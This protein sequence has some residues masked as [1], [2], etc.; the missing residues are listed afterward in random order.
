MFVEGIVEYKDCSILYMDLL[1]TN[2]VVYL[3]EIL[4]RH[5]FVIV[6]ISNGG[7][8]SVKDIEACRETNLRDLYLKYIFRIDNSVLNLF[9]SLKT[10]LVW[11]DQSFEDQEFDLFHGEE[12]KHLMSISPEDKRDYGAIYILNEEGITYSSYEIYSDNVKENPCAVISI[13]EIENKSDPVILEIPNDIIE[14]ISKDDGSRIM[15]EDVNF[16]GYKDILYLGDNNGLYLH[17]QCNGFLWN[18]ETGKYELCKSL[19]AHFGFIDSERKRLTY[20][21]HLSIDDETYYIYEY[22]DGEFQEKRLETEYKRDASNP[23]E[24]VWNYYENGELLEKLILEYSN[25]ETAYYTFYDR[26]NHIVNGEFPEEKSYS[27]LGMQYFP[28]F[29]FYFFG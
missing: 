18:E 29:D 9:D 13:R 22:D 1:G 10:V 4:P 26:D 17:H 20:Y 3:D 23:E 24:L 5:N 11:T 16:D 12:W 21:S 28:E 2:T 15:L 25:G 19:P 6:E 7:M 14:W 27:E 8:L